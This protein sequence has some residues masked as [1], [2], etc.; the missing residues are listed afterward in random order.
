MTRALLI[1]LGLMLVAVS[2]AAGQ[3]FAADSKRLGDG[4]M[5]IV[6]QE[7]ARRARSSVLEVTIKAPGSSVATSMFIACSLR[8]LAEQRGGHRHI[9]KVDDFP[10]RGQM[11]VGFLANPDEDP[12]DVDPDFPRLGPD[13]V[14]DL[15]QFAGLCAQMK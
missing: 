10:S 6:I 4:Q 3:L 1:S 2:P 13:A 14:L 15:S 7:V 5:D 8:Q 11:L 9:I 12:R